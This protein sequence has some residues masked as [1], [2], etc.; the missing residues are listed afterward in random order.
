MFSYDPVSRIVWRP[1]PSRYESSIDCSPIRIIRYRPSMVAPSTPYTTCPLES[2]NTAHLVAGVPLSPPPR[3][4]TPMNFSGIG[5]NGGGG[6]GPDGT[7]GV[8][9]EGLVSR[10]DGGGGGAAFDLNRKR[11]R[12]LAAGFGF[13]SLNAWRCTS[14]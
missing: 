5:G 6:G 12:S 14:G 1:R 3:T 11:F 9:S 2:L 8:V 10:A 4:T 13:W 7:G